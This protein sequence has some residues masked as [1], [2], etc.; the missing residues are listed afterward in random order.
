MRAVSLAAILSLTTALGCRGERSPQEPL[1]DPAAPSPPTSDLDELRAFAR[2]YGYVRYFHPSDEAAAIDW[3]A[4]AVHGVQRVTQADDRE[5]LR[6]ALQEL[7]LP[8]APSL[9]LLAE[10]ETPSGASPWP[11]DVEGLEV[12]AWQHAGYGFGDMSSAYSSKRTSRPRAVPVGHQRTV[13]VVQRLEQGMEDLRGRAIRLRAWAKVDPEAPQA[14]V[15]LYLRIGQPDDRRVWASGADYNALEWGELRLEHEVPADAD[16]ITLGAAVT[17]QGAAWLDDFV[18]EAREGNGWR[19]VPLVDPGFEATEEIETALAGG[20]E[21]RPTGVWQLDAPNFRHQ[22]RKQA[23][24]G[25]RALWLA[26]KSIQLTRDPFEPRPEPGEWIEEPLGVGLW[27]R[28]PLA[29]LSEDGHTLA[30]PDAPRAELPDLSALPRSAEDPAVRIAAVIVTWNVFQHFFPYFDVVDTDWSAVLDQALAEALLDADPAQTQETLEHMV[31]ALH[32]G[33][34]NVLPPD[35]RDLLRVSVSFGRVEGKVVVL[36]APEDEGLRRGDVVRRFEGR[37]VDEAIARAARRVSGSPQWIEHRLLAWSG[38]TEG[39]ADVPVS[40]EIERDG[41]VMT[42]E[43]ARRDVETPPVFPHEAMEELPGGRWYVDL[44]RASW[45]EISPKL[46]ALAEAP[47]IVFDLRAYPQGSNFQILQHLMT[48]PEH[49]HWM[50]VPHIIRPDHQGPA[51]W[52]ELGWD[53]T[54][55]EP[56]IGGKV[57]FI[58]GGGAISYAESVMGYVEGL[59]LGEIVGGPTAGANGNVNPFTT[60]GGYV[61]ISTGMRVLKHDGRPHHGVGVTP[62]VPLA[63]TLEGIRAGRDELF[64]RALALVSAG[65]APS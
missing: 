28:L 49:D 34:G 55:A 64:E 5:Q 24:G 62:T 60:P 9:E 22:L 65:R 38:L 14:G 45:E 36:T 10:G 4:F 30:P 46:K 40:F 15:R 44:S 12:V 52:E 27:C 35:A 19:E 54:P 21:P 56:H 26:R 48:E 41:E 61:I 63:P 39:P 42:V 17:G 53:L 16:R 6:A 50:F 51:E 58:T 8:V 29:L 1:V 47:G 18:L 13:T 31:A 59:K 32:D 23:H 33:H 57:A 43:V 25:Q 37:D 7:F 2:L 20:D 3:D 11:A